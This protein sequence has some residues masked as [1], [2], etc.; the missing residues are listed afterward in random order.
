MLLNGWG[1]KLSPPPVQT[2]ENSLLLRISNK[3]PSFLFLFHSNT[4]FFP[5]EKEG[6]DITVM[7]P[8]LISG[9]I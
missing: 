8:Y 5:A 9:G 3:F 2:N 6:S 7:R 4:F 1:E